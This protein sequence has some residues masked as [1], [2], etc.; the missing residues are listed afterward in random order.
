MRL[1]RRLLW[2]ALGAVVVGGAIGLWLTS[3]ERVDAA[4]YAGL[5]GVPSQGEMVFNAAGCKSCHTSETDKSQLALVGGKAFLSDFGTFYAPNISSDPVYGI[6]AWSFMDFANALQ[7]GVSPDGQHYYP[8]F[9]YTTYTRMT[10]QDVVD[11]W[12][13]LLLQPAAAT[14]SKPHDV[15]FPF[16]IRR[17]LGLWKLL[18][19]NDDWVIEDTT[20]ERGRYLVEAMAHCAECHTARNAIGGLDTANWLGGAP[21]PSGKGIIPDIT[22]AALQWSA[23][24]IAFYLEQGFTPDF[25]SAGGQMVAVIDNMAKLPPEDRAAIAEYL[26]ALKP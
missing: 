19:L 9:P 1:S 21:N 20:T 2:S 14:P 5:T 6:G 22:P 23:L 3:P 13:Y 17:G 15:G 16:N 7:K 24:D 4:D 25:D 8:A 10:P 12:S 26:V 11:L 18:Y